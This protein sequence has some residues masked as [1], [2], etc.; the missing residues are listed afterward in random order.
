M[1]PVYPEPVEGPTP[2]FPQLS[3]LNS[4][5]E[6]SD[7]MVIPSRLILTAGI[8]TLGVS[9]A[10][11]AGADAILDGDGLHG[12]GLTQG[13]GLLVLQALVGRR[14]AVNGVE[15]AGTCRTAHGHLRGFLKGCD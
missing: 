14:R 7:L 8:H 1:R 13:D 12:G 2:K 3:T 5:L 6:R 15:D 4:Q 11:H 10:G 9:A